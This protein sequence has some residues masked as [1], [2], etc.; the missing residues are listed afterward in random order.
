MGRIDKRVAVH[1]AITEE[2]GVL[3]A[4]NHVEHA[5]LL[6]KG[7]VRL[8]AY[9]VIGGAL[10]ILRTKLHRRPRPAAASGIGEPNGLHRTEA[11]RIA[12]SAGNLLD[13]LARLEKIALLE[14]FGHHA[15]GAKKRIDEGLV[16]LF[17]HRGVE[18]VALPFLL[19]ARLREQHVGIERRRIDDGRRGIEK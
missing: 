7:E 19:I 14:L 15:I 10:A 2:L 18:V 1:D 12:T 8:E 6:S 4:R 11:R 5:L 13:R 3:K 16:L 17:I 9:E